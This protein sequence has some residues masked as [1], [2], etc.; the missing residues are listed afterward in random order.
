MVRHTLRV[1]LLV[2]LVLATA[3]A[4][5]TALS[6]TTS[7]SQR[8]PMP[9]GPECPPR[10]SSTRPVPATGAAANGAIDQVTLP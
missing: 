2:G 9:C 4:L 3:T 6:I 1:A 10:G 5:G 7:P 8:Q